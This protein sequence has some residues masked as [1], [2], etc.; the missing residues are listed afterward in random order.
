M[1]TN[2]LIDYYANLLIMQYKGKP[3]AYETVRA[4]VAGFNMPQT[5]VETVTFS[6]VPAS[7]TFVLSYDGVNTATIN[8]NDSA[9]AVQTKLRAIPG[10]EDILVTGAIADGTLTV[11]FDGVDVPAKILEVVSTSLQTSAPGPVFIRITETDEILPIAVQNG[12]NLVGENLAIG[13]QLDV[14]GKYAGVVRTGPGFSSQVTLS[15]QDFL[16]LIKMAIVKNNS[17]ASLGDIQELLA[18][19]FPDQVL[20]FDTQLMKIFYYIS[21]DLGSQDLIQAF[22]TQKIL[23]KPMGVRISVILYVPTINNFYGFRTYTYI[24]TNN[25]GFNS[26]HDWKTDST[27]LSYQD[28][29]PLPP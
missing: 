7:G 29:I 13:K 20:I 1:N 15:D 11:I 10:L 21:S 17:S 9:S 19:F 23:P 12:Y 27:W 14:L 5:T 28:A 25:K 26:Y 2:E 3:K 8:W 16:S 6:G 18:T 4:I 24:D 22:I